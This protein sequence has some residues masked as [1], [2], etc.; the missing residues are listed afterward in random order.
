MTATIRT[1]GDARM[2]RRDL[3]VE[4]RIANGVANLVIAASRAEGGKAT[5]E[6]RLA[7]KRETRGNANHVLLGNTHVD[8]ALRIEILKLLGGGGAG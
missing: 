2:R 4:A 1:H 3:D 8:E 5:G 7:N 6:D